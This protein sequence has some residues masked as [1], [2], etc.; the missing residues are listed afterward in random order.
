MVERGAGADSAGHRRPLASRVARSALV[1]P[2]A[3]SRETT[4]RFAVSRLDWTL[5]RGE[6]SVGCPRID[7]E[8]LKLGIVVSERT[9]SRYLR[10]G[11]GVSQTWRTFLENHLGQFTLMSQVL[12]PFGPGD[13]VVDAFATTS[14][15]APSSDHPSGSRQCA[16]AGRPASVR[17]IGLGLPCIQDH[18]HDRKGM[19]RSAGR[20]P[21]RPGCAQLTHGEHA[22]SRFAPARTTQLQPLTV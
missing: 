22:E 1:A 5:G 15:A 10:G 17:H 20:A 9:V 8:L 7:G 12:S 3:T 13:D 21:P 16:L 11:Q 4:L 2:F 18:V 14:C 19:Q 6:S